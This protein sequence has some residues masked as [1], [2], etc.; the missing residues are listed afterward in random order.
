VPLSESAIAHGQEV[1]GGTG[2]E[3]LHA[4]AEA[5]H[6]AAR[7][8]PPLPIPVRPGSRV[9][10]T[11]DSQPVTFQDDLNEFTSRAGVTMETAAFSGASAC[12]MTGNPAF[13]EF[14]VVV[15]SFRGNSYTPCMTSTASTPTQVAVKTA[16]NAIDICLDS[17]AICIVV[18]QP[19][20]APPSDMIVKT[21]M[22]NSELQRLATLHSNVH[23]A[24]CGQSV[25]TNGR[26][27]AAWRDLDGVHL[28]DAGQR[29][30]ATC[31]AAQLNL[32]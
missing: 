11:G 12:D 21:S 22:L 13:R 28:N 8:E 26:Y 4:A 25:M 30:F 20:E 6:T 32:S 16:R 9:L 17:A 31:I 1:V 3:G 15:V 7:V 18:G 24:D 29:S 10:L 2:F 27:E 23:F 19:H 14:D 5:Q